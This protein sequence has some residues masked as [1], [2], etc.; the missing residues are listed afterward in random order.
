MLTPFAPSTC[1]SCLNQK[2]SVEIEEKGAQRSFLHIFVASD[3]I[4]LGK[5]SVYSTIEIN[6][7]LF[8]AGKRQ[9]DINNK[10]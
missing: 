8:N 1:Q 7:F 2:K 4:K 5:I 10:K 3:N 6:I 9:Y